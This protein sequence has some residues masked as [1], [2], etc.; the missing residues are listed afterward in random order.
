MLKQR[1]GWRKDFFVKGHTSV[2]QDQRRIG[3]IIRERPT[4]TSGRSVIFSEK[5]GP[6][7]DYVKSVG[8]IHDIRDVNIPPGS[9]IVS[10][11]FQQ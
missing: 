1:C 4:S 3:A 6:K 2:L 7:R 9:S 5:P 8:I 11:V 10:L